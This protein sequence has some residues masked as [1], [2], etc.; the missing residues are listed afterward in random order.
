MSTRRSAT[1]SRPTS[2]WSVLWTRAAPRVGADRRALQDRAA[3]RLSQCRFR[4]GSVPGRRECPTA[5]ACDHDLE[6]VHAD[7]A[8]SGDGGITPCRG[9]VE[10]VRGLRTTRRSKRDRFLTEPPRAA[11]RRPAA[12]ERRHT[13][14]DGRGRGWSRVAEGRRELVVSAGSGCAKG[15]VH[16]LRSQL[17]P[18]V[19]LPTSY[20]GC[21]SPCA[22]LPE[23]G[24]ILN[25]Q[26]VNGQQTA[27]LLIRGGNVQPVGLEVTGASSPT[28]TPRKGVVRMRPASAAPSVASMAVAAHELGPRSA[29]PAEQ[30]V[31]SQ[32]TIWCQRAVRPSIGILQITSI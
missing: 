11:R 1:R 14:S 3:R 23:V 4:Q 2:R 25:S 15:D 30:R 21:A 6:L 31:M 8:R 10:P 27:Q 12:P 29:A 5:A 16:V 13:V 24:N 22:G 9:S 20:S 26:G 32:R 7:G 28:T 17:Y 18:F 19:M